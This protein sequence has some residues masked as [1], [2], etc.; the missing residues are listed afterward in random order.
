M[1]TTN[2][3]QHLDNE[4]ENFISNLGKVTVFHSPEPQMVV[5]ATKMDADSLDSI[6]T[7]VECLQISRDH[8]LNV[9]VAK[10]LLTNDPAYVNIVRELNQAFL[11]I[12]DLN[13]LDNLDKCQYLDQHDGNTK[14]ILGS[15]LMAKVYEHDNPPALPPRNRCDVLDG[16]EA[17]SVL[18]P[19]P[20]RL[21]GRKVTLP[22]YDQQSQKPETAG[23]YET[24]KDTNEKEDATCHIY[25]SV[26]DSFSDDGYEDIGDDSDDYEY[27]DFNN[28]VTATPQK[29]VSVPSKDHVTMMSEEDQYYLMSGSVPKNE[30]KDGENSTGTL[31][32]ERRNKS[33]VLPPTPT[34]LKGKKFTLPTCDQQSRKTVG[35]YET[36]KDTNE[37][38]DTTCHIYESVSDCSKDDGYSDINDHEDDD[39]DGYE[40]IEVNGHVNTTSHNYVDM[41][42]PQKHASVSSKGHVT[43]VSREDQYYLMSGSVPKNERNDDEDSTETLKLERRNKRPALPPTP[44]H[45]KGKKFTLLTCDQ[46]SRKTVGQY[47]TCKDTNE[48]EDTTCHMYESVNDCL[49]DDGY[50][51]DIDD[52]EDDDSDGY[53]YIEVNGH[54]TATSHDYVDMTS[55]KH[56][57]MTSKDHVAMMSEEDQYFPMTGFVPKN[58]RNDDENS[59][60]SLKLERRNTN[61]DETTRL[62]NLAG[63]IV[64]KDPSAG[65]KTSS[66]ITMPEPNNNVITLKADYKT[67][68]N[69]SIPTNLSSLSVD[70]VGRLLTN[71]NM[72]CYANTFQEE[73]I[74]GE[75]LMELD[76]TALK[77]LHLMSYFHVKKLMN[78]IASWRADNDS[79]TH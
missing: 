5:V 55:P 45:L 57:S 34:H 50:V 78:F 20:T 13:E 52:H 21:K 70:G 74:D 76:E 66:E 8:S 2:E 42:S 43:M 65:S 14:G 28:H 59:T 62:E 61:L 68:Q 19:K 56:V 63:R 39:S 3:N 9:S 69:V 1:P 22:N 31:R 18:P 75:I 38:E 15:V 37:K 47:E 67:S 77:S 16:N 35:Q 17:S 25:K 6:K 10:E 49:R 4:F 26:S 54:V 79:N 24:R 64:L 36:C 40:Y 53:E 29:H 73:Q 11:G 58:E 60:E 12:Y 23:Q 41:T 51:A 30:R 32:L 46:Q 72:E 71:L 33:P 44:T 48:K 7:S 27:V